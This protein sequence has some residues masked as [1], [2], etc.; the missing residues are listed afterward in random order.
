MIYSML[1]ERIQTL[2]DKVLNPGVY[3]V[4][5][6]GTTLA[7]GVYVCRLSSGAYSSS[8]KLVLLK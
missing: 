3:T 5:F 1:G 8:V 7:N 4:M 2:V 6:D